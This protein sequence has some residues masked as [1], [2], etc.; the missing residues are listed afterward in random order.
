[1]FHQWVTP[2]LWH[3]LR[4]VVI[5]RYLLSPFC[6]SVRGWVWPTQKQPNVRQYK[7]ARVVPCT[8]WLSTSVESLNRGCELPLA[9]FTARQHVMQRAVLPRPFCPSLCLSNVYFVTKRKK[10]YYIAW[11]I[12]HPSLLTKRMVD[13]AIPS[14]W[15]FG[16]NWL[17]WSEN[18]D[19]QWIF[20]RA[21]Q[22]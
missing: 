15:N 9:I 20:A 16:P 8:Q 11:D 2:V 22:P 17:C 6:L 5:P 3:L 13:G 7:T 19:F 1:M 4:Q 12:I 18:A 10:L 21:P 14:T